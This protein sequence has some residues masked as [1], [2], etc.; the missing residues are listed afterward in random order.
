MSIV[1]NMRVFDAPSHV[2]RTTT[3]GDMTS[4]LIWFAHLQTT[5][6]V[7]EVVLQPSD[8]VNC[9]VYVPADRQ[10]NVAP[11]E[12]EVS[13]LQPSPEQPRGLVKNWL[14]W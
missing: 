6:T 14:D 3:C 11:H 13:R 2:F 10:R 1:G 12:A 9:S 8:I 5:G 7:S 4:A